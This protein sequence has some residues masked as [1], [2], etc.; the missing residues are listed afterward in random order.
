M[1]LR[2]LA[3][4]KPGQAPIR[5]H[6]A[7]AM[8]FHHPIAP[9]PNYKE[10]HVLDV[11]FKIFSSLI[12]IWSSLSD[13]QKESICKTFTDLFEDLFRAYYKANSGGAQ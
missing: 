12:Q 2:Q 1:T 9:A 11:L 3:S 8:G 13:E 6:M 5:H 10:F 7:A 4:P